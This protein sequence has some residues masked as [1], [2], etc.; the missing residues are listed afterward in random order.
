MLFSLKGHP[1]SSSESIEKSGYYL[2]DVRLNPLSF[3]AQRLQNGRNFP[4]M[5]KINMTHQYIIAKS[6]YRKN[7][8]SAKRNIQGPKTNRNAITASHQVIEYRFENDLEKFKKLCS[9]SSMLFFISISS[10]SASCNYILII[11]SILS[12]Y[13]TGQGLK[14]CRNSELQP[15]LLTGESREFAGN[16]SVTH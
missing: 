5:D 13:A 14:L 9:K 16:V 6:R 12:P 8:P 15:I 11:C 1:L 4:R 10:A 2:E 7:I 3:S